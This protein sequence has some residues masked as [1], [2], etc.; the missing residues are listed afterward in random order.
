MNKKADKISPSQQAVKL[1]DM[2]YHSAMGDNWNVFI[3]SRA[4]DI[5][6][7]IYKQTLP[8]CELKFKKSLKKY[9]DEVIIE[10]DKK[11]IKK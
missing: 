2:V 4:K 5:A 7:E 9:W 8:Y 1:C 6:K 10:I 11:Q 3:V